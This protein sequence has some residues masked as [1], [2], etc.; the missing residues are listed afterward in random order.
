MAIGIDDATTDS[1]LKDP[2]IGFFGFIGRPD[3]GWTLR[4]KLTPRARCLIRHSGAAPVVVLEDANRALAVDAIVEGGFYHAGQACVSMQRIFVPR[5]HARHFAHDLARRA[6]VLRL[7][8]PKRSE[9][10]VGPLI[11]PEEVERVDSW[12]QEAVRSGAQCVTGGTRIHRSIYEP[13]VLLEPP[14]DAKVSRCEISGPVVCVYG[15]HALRDAIARANA[16]P[17]V[18]Q[19]VVFTSDIDRALHLYRHFD[20]CAVMVNDVATFRIDAMPCAGLRR[21]TFGSGGIRDTID[22]MQTEKVLVLHSR[23]L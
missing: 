2:R 17:F 16:S 3:V 1:V 13:T 9:T 11:R 14:A 18:F 7:G 19:A 5:S 22:E 20:G 6:S 23:E 10:D 8:D 4:S 15:Y 12:V 21:S